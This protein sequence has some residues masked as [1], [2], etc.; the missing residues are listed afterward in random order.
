MRRG[1]CSRAG[2]KPIGSE[3]VEFRSPDG[4]Q[5]R[6]GTAVPHFDPLNT[7]YGLA[8]ESQQVMLQRSV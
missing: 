4:A 3:G 5:R 6:P 2:A 7:G 8:R 1:V